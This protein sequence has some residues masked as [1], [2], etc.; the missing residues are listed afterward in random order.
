MVLNSPKMG[1]DREP[2]APRIQ[3][4]SAS[5][6][7]PATDRAVT[8]RSATRTQAGRTPVLH[9]HPELTL[10]ARPS[11]SVLSAACCALC[12]ADALGCSA[13]VAPLTLLWSAHTAGSGPAIRARPG[14]SAGGWFLASRPAVVA[15]PRGGRVPRPLALAVAPGVPV[16]LDGRPQPETREHP[17]R[18]PVR[19]GV[20]RSASLESSRLGARGDRRVPWV[21]SL[22]DEGI[23]CR[24]SSST[25][26]AGWCFP[27]T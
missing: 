3:A 7:S 19:P 13:S 12:G 11:G 26:M 20:G 23:V 1:P 15:C 18:G 2:C 9:Q 22:I 8:S 6:P 17:R 10:C 14:R 25:G 21:H 24:R 4:P 16:Q 5:K 27:P